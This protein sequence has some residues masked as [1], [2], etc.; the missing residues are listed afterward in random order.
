MLAMIFDALFMWTG[1][2]MFLC[3]CVLNYFSYTASGSQF[4]EMKS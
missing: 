2:S 1:S 4:H 3:E